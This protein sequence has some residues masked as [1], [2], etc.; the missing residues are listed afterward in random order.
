[1]KDE[2]IDNIKINWTQIIECSKE[3]IKTLKENLD[4]EK[5]DEK[6]KEIIQDFIK[7]YSKAKEEIRSNT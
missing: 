7:K 4:N 3:D 2:D 5:S 1:M 6:D